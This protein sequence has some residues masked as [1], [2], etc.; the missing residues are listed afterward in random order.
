MGAKAAAAAATLTFVAQ[1]AAPALLA[2]A[3]VRL[4]AG[5]VHATGISDALLAGGALPAEA[6]VA[7]VGPRTVALVAHAA[8][9]TDGLLAVFALPAG[10]TDDLALVRAGE[11]AVDVVA[12]P[13]QDVALF[14]KVVRLTGHPVGVGQRGR[15][16]LV[17]AIGPLVLDRQPAVHRVLND[18]LL[19]VEVVGSGELGLKVVAQAVVEAGQRVARLLR[20]GHLRAELLEARRRLIPGVQD[21]REGALVVFLLLLLLLPNI[22]CERGGQMLA[23]HEALAKSGRAERRA[24][25]WPVSRRRAARKHLP[26]R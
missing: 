13:A 4:A 5:S 20:Q 14:A 8:R 10:Q 12:G 22:G 16:R 3:L 25:L 24:R 17:H 11:V 23:S 26:A 19:L 2:I 21:Q 18:R 6:T 15:V 7:L 9:Q 1:K